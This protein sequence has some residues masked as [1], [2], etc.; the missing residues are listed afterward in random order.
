[1]L[2]FDSGGNIMLQGAIVVFAVMAVILF[3]GNVLD[4]LN[5]P[6][7]KV[8]PARVLLK[9]DRGENMGMRR[10][11][12]A[13]H[14]VTFEFEDRRIIILAIPKN[15]YESVT[16][17]TKGVLVYAHAGFIKRYRQFH[18]GKTLAE[19]INPDLN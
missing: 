12:F 8:A 15:L 1:M 7:P 17:D 9:E 5:V 6:K 13:V 4:L 14:R 10:P 3:H 11:L 16:K 2:S 18:I 19:I